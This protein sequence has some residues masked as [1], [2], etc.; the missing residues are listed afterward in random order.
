MLFLLHSSLSKSFTSIP[1]AF[2]VF[3]Y[4]RASLTAK[5]NFGKLLPYDSP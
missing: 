3:S 1:N 4:K 2:N 5:F